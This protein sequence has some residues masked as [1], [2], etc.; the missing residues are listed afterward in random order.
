MEKIKPSILSSP[1]NSFIDIT[2]AKCYNI[3]KPK[4]KLIFLIG[5]MY[6]SIEYFNAH[7]GNIF[8]TNPYEFEMIE[9]F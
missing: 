6:Y 5:I 2:F 3:I 9:I 4:D 7:I 1:T 8:G